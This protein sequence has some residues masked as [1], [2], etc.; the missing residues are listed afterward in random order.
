MTPDNEPNS[1]AGRDGTDVRITVS[2]L[3]KRFQRSSG[4]GEVVPVDDV[5]LE[6]MAGELLVLLGPSGC[7]KTTLLRCIAG[8]ERPESGRIA[9]HGREVV[10]S[11]KKLFVPP[12]RRPVSMIFQSYALWPHMSVVENI[13]YPLVCQRRPKPEIR[14]KVA[15]AMTMVGLDGLKDQYPGKLSGGQQQRVALAR[16]IVADASVIL[17]DE[18][19]SNVDA[20]VRERLRLELLEMQRTIGFTGV[21]VTHDQSEALEVA[22]RVAV[23]HDGRIE[24]LGSPQQVYEYPSSRYVAEFVGVANMWQGVVVDTSPSGVV[25]N[26]DVGKTVA[27]LQPGSGF[28]ATPSEK[29]WVVT[30]PENLAVTSLQPNDANAWKGEVKAKTFL[31]PYTQFIVV[32]ADEHVRVWT[33]DSQAIEEGQQ[34]WITAQPQH[35]RL[36]PERYCLAHDEGSQK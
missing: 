7:G 2:N 8:L 30:R 11:D 28:S 10:N 1:E 27:D 32:S 6:V 34:V 13:A 24:Q 5:S 35:V 31:G 23:L 29:V 9:I 33:S 21:Y 16:A 20:K 4:A 26:T 36:L 15:E 17:F 12:D 18:P 25:V 22:D 19:L 3:V 14:E